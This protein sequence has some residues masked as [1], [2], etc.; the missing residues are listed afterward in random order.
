MR[1][2]WFPSHRGFSRLLDELRETRAE[3]AAL[4]VGRE[5]LRVSRDLHD[6]LGQSLSAVALKGD[7]AIRL[8]RTDPPAARA[9]IESLTGLAR[10]AIRGIHAV[11]RDEHA[12]SLRTETEGAAAPLSAAGIHAPTDADLPDLAPPLERVLAWAVS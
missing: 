11:S 8:L 6:L 3:L 1:R 9:E 5:R 7:L 2:T 10:D 12:V 4:A